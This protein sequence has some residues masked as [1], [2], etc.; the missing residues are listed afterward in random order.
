[1]VPEL[2]LQVLASSGPSE[3]IPYVMVSA[4]LSMYKAQ[5]EHS[6]AGV[7][8]RKPAQQAEVEGRSPNHVEAF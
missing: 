1:V 2:S 7:E 5:A 4:F 6:E 3:V 8:V